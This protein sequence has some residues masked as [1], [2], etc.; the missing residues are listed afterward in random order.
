VYSAFA[1]FALAEVPQLQL[2]L[3]ARLE[4]ESP[5]GPQRFD[6]RRQDCWE[7]QLGVLVMPAS[8]QSA[9]KAMHDEEEALPALVAWK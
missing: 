8:P 5:H 7:L 3:L 4:L 9:L 2:E 6:S 1:L